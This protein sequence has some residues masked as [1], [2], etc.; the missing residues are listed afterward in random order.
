MGI[1]VPPRTERNGGRQ[2][3]QNSAQAVGNSVKG[4]SMPDASASEVLHTCSPAKEMPGL[5]VQDWTG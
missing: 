5:E 4:T 2:N 3:Y 1:L